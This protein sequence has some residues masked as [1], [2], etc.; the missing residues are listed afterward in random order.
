MKKGVM[1]EGRQML[2]K[3]DSEGMDLTARREGLKLFFDVF[4]HLTTLAS[5]S[6]VI[7]VTFLGS[8]QSTPKWRIMIA[9]SFLGFLVA[10]VGSILVLLSTARTIRRNDTTDQLPDALGNRGYYIAVVGFAAGIGCLALFGL[11]NL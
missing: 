5:G 1:R 4:K 9:M 8:Q 2:G 6:I 10:I 7:L 3:P 11:R